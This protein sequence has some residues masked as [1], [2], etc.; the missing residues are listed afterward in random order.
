M[1]LGGKDVPAYVAGMVGLTSFDVGQRATAVSGYLQGYCDATED[2]QCSLLPVTIPVNEV[3]CDGQNRPVTTGE[4]WARYHVYRI[5]LCRSDPGNVGWLDWT[6]PAGG[7]SE[8]VCAIV[9][10]NN[11]SITLPS[12][13]YVSQTGNPNGGGGPCGMS[14]EEAL[15]LYDGK[16]VLIPQFDATCDD[17]PDNSQVNSPPN[18]GCPA[19]ALGGHG[20]QQWYRMPSF[21]FL[22][23]CSPTT[24]G[25]DGLHGAYIQGNDSAVC[26][27][28]NGATSCLVGRF[29]DLLATGTVGAGVGGGQGST[30][31]VGIQLVR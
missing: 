29:V 24:A 31:V 15:R 14:I 8:L 11:P 4:P 10:P 23:L 13:Q 27:T 21:A 5:P 9:N 18:F 20:Q 26:D 2:E 12:W 3:T 7:A 17:D 1:V 6:P 28:G 30:K 25:C 19:G 16:V 22:E